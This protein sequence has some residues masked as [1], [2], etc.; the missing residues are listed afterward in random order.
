M[1]NEQ[2]EEQKEEVTICML[3]HA[4][5]CLQMDGGDQKCSEL[6]GTHESACTQ[7]PS[8]DERGKLSV[9]D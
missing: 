5:M 8:R 2:Q 3:K 6:G 9:S 7:R 1:L 4:G